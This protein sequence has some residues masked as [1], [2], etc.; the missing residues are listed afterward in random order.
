MTHEGETMTPC[1]LRM[2]SVASGL[3][4]FGMV[5]FALTLILLF[6]SSRASADT[7]DTYVFSGASAVLGVAPETVALETITGGFTFDA[8]T[9]EV[10]AVDI[11]LTGNSAYAG[12]FTASSLSDGGLPFDVLNPVVNAGVTAFINLTF[13]SDFGASP[14]PLVG[15]NW[16]STS[17]GGGSGVPTSDLEGEI[18]I[19]GTSTSAV[20][21][22]SSFIL[23]LVPLV[24]TV[25]FLK[26]RDRAVARLS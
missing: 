20:P 2:S 8:T 14:D 12:S 26:R 1:A 11:T 13:A 25:G 15:F 16:V 18:V 10:S 17:G 19:S 9:N 21:E 4:P 6:A 5:F 22:P 3:R 24:A 23:I 7:V